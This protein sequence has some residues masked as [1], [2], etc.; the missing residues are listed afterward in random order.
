M[1]TRFIAA[2]AFG[3]AVA[4]GGLEAAERFQKLGAAQVR[5]R[6]AGME[7]TD[8]VHWR[9]IFEPNGTLTSWAMSRKTVGK[10]RVD[11]DQLCLE[12][13]GDE[14]TCYQ[15]WVSVKKIELRREGSTLPL[16]GILQKAGTR[17]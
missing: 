7:M 13:P 6:L 3:L 1:R 2:A 8:G 10:W 12:R 11:K 16:E 15:V 4:S 5:A 17:P 14:A 9:D